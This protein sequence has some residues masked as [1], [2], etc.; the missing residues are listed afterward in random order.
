MRRSLAALVVLA[1][2]AVAACS[3][4]ASPSPSGAASEPPPSAAP[5]SEPAPSVAGDPCAPSTASGT[6]TAAI[7]DFSFNPATVTA[8]VGDVVV[9]TNE[10]E[11]PHTATLDDFAACDTGNLS[12]G[13]SGGIVFEA[14]GTY[15]FHCTIH[16]QMKGTV[17]VTG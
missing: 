12:G 9:W 13:D 16:A 7:R 1:A 11:A 5:P 8:K 17:E 14:A 10:G 15:A 2:F 6:V 4:G 3:G